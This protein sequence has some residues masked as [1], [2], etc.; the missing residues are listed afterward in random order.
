MFVLL[1]SKS[2]RTVNNILRIATF[3]CY[4]ALRFLYNCFK[5]HP[6]GNVIVSGGS[7]EASPGSGI[8]RGVRGLARRL[9]SRYVGYNVN[10]T[11]S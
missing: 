9:R 4:N 6:L 11:D 8:P 2:R 5:I 1:I 3:L 7:K 10:F